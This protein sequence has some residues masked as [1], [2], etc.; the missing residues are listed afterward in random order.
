MPGEGQPPSEP[1]PQMEPTA[2]YIAVGQILSA[3]GL[4]GELKVEPLTDFPERFEVGRSL[5]TG[6]ERR[7]IEGCRWYRGKLYL[8]LSGIDSASAAARLRHRLLEIP[9]KELKPLAAG[10]YYQ[11]Q[12][13]GLSVRTTAGLPLGRVREVLSTGSND[14]FVVHG[15]MGEVLLPA[16][17]DV[18]KKIDLEAGYMEV[19]L[20]NGLV[21]RQRQR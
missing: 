12:V 20:V 19:E 16:I 1:Q 5:Y 17:G 4:R 21:T 18:V 10:D 11:F 9:E 3:H 7:I 2:G 6:G 14:V 8:K 13:V 15:M